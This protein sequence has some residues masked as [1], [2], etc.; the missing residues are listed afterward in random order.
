MHDRSEA[1]HIFVQFQT[2]VEHLLDTKVKCVQSDWGGSIKNSITIFRSLGIAHRVSCL[3]THQQ[4]ESAEHKH[5][6]IVETGLALLAHASMLIK[7]WDKAFVTPTYLMNQLPTRVIDNLSSLSRL[8]NTQPNYSMLKIFGCACWPHLRP[9]MKHKLSF[10]SKPCVFLGYSSL[11]KGDKCLDEDI[12]HVY[13]SWDAIF[14]EVVFPSLIL[15]QTMQIHNLLNVV[16]V[17]IGTLTIC[18]IC[19]HLPICV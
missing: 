5:H 1:Q 10:H 9:Y 6:H 12:S 15:H 19:F 3:H 18:L 13:I 17:L 16:L 7:F 8:F 14:N 4:N 2:H 11:H